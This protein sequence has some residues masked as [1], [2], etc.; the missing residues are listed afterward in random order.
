MVRKSSFNS[1]KIKV[2]IIFM[3]VFVLFLL[4]NILTPLYAD[5]YSYSFS[6]ATGERINNISQIIPSQ[7]IHYYNLN[8]RSIAH[9]LA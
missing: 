1:E 9:I 2:G 6:F 7:I 5:D 4:L 3:T 8:G